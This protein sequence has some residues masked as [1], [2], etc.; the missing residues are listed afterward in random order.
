MFPIKNTIF[1]ILFTCCFAQF[2]LAQSLLSP[3]DAIKITLENNYDIKVAQNNITIAQKNTDR[4]LNGYNPTVNAAAGTNATFGGSSQKFSSGNENTVSNAF[5]W[6]ANASITANYTL[7]DKTRD[8]NLQQ[9]KE[10][11]QLSDLQ[12][13]QTIE[14]NLL[15]VF[16]NYY[17]LARLTQNRKVLEETIKVSRKRL[18]RAQYQYDYGQGIR[19]NILNAEVDIQRDSINIINIDNQVATTRRLLNVIMGRNVNEGLEV[20]TLVNYNSTLTF[21]QLLENTQN[22][23]I[24]IQ[25]I[26]KNLDISAIDFDIIE[27]SKRPV[28]GASASYNFSFSDNASG[29]FIDLSNSRGLTAGLN[30]SWNLYDGGRRKVQKDIARIGVENQTILKQQLLQQLEGEVTNTWAAYQ[31]ALFVLQTE[32]QNIATAEL[33]FQRTEEQFKIGQVTSVEFRQAQLN[34]LNAKTNRN[35]AKYNAKILEVQLMQLAGNIMD[36]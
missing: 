22:R 9:L 35:A 24:V 27:S 17:E 26:N 32:E 15:Q 13:R 11:V 31:N 10:I 34:L 20:D 6:G 19:L 21:E 4:A 16:I 23:N 2:G 8:I 1:I 18:Q 14:N 36:I 29:S 5:N 25:I 30:L 3:T 7:L 33:N 28:V 12:L